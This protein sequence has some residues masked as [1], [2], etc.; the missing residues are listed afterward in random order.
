MYSSHSI[1]RVTCLRL[2]LAVDLGPIG[3]EVAAM[4]LLGADC[5]KQR[6][7]QRVV[8]HLRRHWPAEPRACQ[9]FQR[10]PDRRRCDT[11]AAGNLVEPDPG[12]PQTKHVAHSAHRHPL[13]WHPLPRAKPKERTLI[14][15]AEAPSNRARSSRNGGRNHLGTPSDIK[16]EWRA[17]S[18]R[19]RGRLPP[20][21]AH[22]KAAGRRER[23]FQ[24]FEPL[25][26]ELRIEK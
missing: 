9:S 5:R 6:R 1:A 20:E 15:P 26:V 24:E 4:T 16:S 11:D 7:L 23:H 25:R 8:G 21:S 18:S 17:T 19:I 14:G 22:G 12:G 10:Q 2:S 13:C 3:L